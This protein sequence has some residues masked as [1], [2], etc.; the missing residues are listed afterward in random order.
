MRNK[1][2]QRRL[3][4]ERAKRKPVTGPPTRFKYSD[5]DRGADKDFFLT[6]PE[7]AMA[8]VTSVLVTKPKRED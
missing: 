6:N 2:R 7:A 3:E 5:A 1:A 4:K 8:L